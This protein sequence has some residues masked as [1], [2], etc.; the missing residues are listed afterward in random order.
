MAIAKL[1]TIEEFLDFVAQHENGFTWFELINGEIIEVSPGRTRYSELGQRVTGAVYIFCNDKPIPCHTSGG[2]G[3]YQ[4]GEH[5]VVPDFAYKRTPMSEDYPDPVAPLW[6]IEIISPTDKPRDIRN[7]RKV[8]AD[9]EILLWEVHYLERRIDVYAPGKPMQSL[10]I[11]DMLDVGDI[12]PGFTLP[13]R[14]IFGETSTPVE[15]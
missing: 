10:G 8:Y 7:K 13:V 5:V 4:I 11:D 6:A 9:A 14:Y 1:Y 2:E 15:Q 12:L 3:A